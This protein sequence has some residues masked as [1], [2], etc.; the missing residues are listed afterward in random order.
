MNTTTNLFIFLIATLF[1]FAATT[2]RYA[3]AQPLEPA[4]SPPETPGRSME[5]NTTSPS[6]STASNNT[7][8][9]TR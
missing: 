7:G 1:I 9:A 8:N 2:I 6:E 3:Q 4:T 5:N